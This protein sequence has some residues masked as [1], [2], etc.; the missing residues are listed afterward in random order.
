MG[1]QSDLRRTRQIYDEMHAI[2]ELPLETRDRV[3]PRIS[4]WSP[5][6]Q[7]AHVSKSNRWILTSVVDIVTGRKTFDTTGSIRP[8]GRLVLRSGVIPRGVGK[9]PS[10]AKP[11]E[12]ISADRLT[13]ELEQ[14]LVK[15]GQIDEHVETAKISRQTFRHPNFGDLNSRQWIRFVRVHTNHHMKI[16]REILSTGTL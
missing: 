13:E 7:I 5:L 11:D 8:L 2:L 12:A 6:Q 4:A 15:I 16:V 9:A 1:I 10:G 14:Q 3:V